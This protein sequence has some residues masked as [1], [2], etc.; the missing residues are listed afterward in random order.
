LNPWLETRL[1]NGGLEEKQ[2]I[3][4]TIIQSTQAPPSTTSAVYGDSNVPTSV[5]ASPFASLENMHRAF[6]D[7]FIE[8]R[9]DS[10]KL[11]EWIKTQNRNRPPLPPQA[12]KV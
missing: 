8:E 7:D 1:L 3:A 12:A 2:S 4:T 6:L 11:Y 9:G 5:I 10:A